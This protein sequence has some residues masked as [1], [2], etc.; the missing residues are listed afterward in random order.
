MD[1]EVQKRLEKLE[2]SIDEDRMS[3]I[4]RTAIRVATLVIVLLSLLLIIFNKLTDV[5]QAGAS[6]WH[7]LVG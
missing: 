4:E 1:L 3:R 2:R 7:Y 5:L 6:I